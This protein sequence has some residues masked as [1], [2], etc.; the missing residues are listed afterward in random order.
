M[1]AERDLYHVPGG[2]ST[3]TWNYG[4][5]HQEVRDLYEKAKVALARAIEG[6]PWEID[7]D[8]ERENFLDMRSPI[9]G[10]R[11][12]SRLTQRE[13][14]QLRH[15]S[16][17]WT[18]SQF[19]H[20]E[21]GAMMLAAQLVNVAPQMDAKHFAASQVI[22]E[23]RHTELYAR[24][25][26]TKLDNEY[27]F[28]ANLQKAFDLILEG[29]EWDKKALGLQVIVEGQAM[30]AFT[31]VKHAAREPLL[32]GIV[33]RVMQDEARHMAFGVLSLQD[34]YHQLP[35]AE[36]RE[37]EEFAFEVA[38]LL[39]DLYYQ[40]A[41]WER[42]GLPVDECREAA[43]LS[44]L[45]IL[46]LRVLYN[47]I[48]PS[49]NRLGLLSERIRPHYEAAGI[50]TALANLPLADDHEADTEHEDTA[51]EMEQGNPGS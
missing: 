47:R 37:R 32:Q 45:N 2:A 36:R 8:P 3:F 1:A 28:Q 14:L 35:E 50:S 48:I 18:L 19:M 38:R 12:W 42:M 26:S 15:E 23:S 44:P 33:Q 22:D 6:L 5:E 29:S 7:V 31:V 13:H 39:R 17:A 10:S 24:Y 21:Q 11:V 27:P 20:A 34:Y 40:E 4:V 41:V 43:T 9:Y 49:L 16:M 51:A 30:S 46:I 25:L